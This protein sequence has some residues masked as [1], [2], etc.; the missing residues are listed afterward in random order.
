MKDARFGEPAGGQFRH[1]SPREAV[2]LASSPKRSPPEVGHVMS[3]RGERPSI[4][5]DCV[6]GEVAGYDLLQPGS[7]DG[8]RLMHSTPQLRLDVLQLR[9]LA[10]PPGLPLKLEVAS[11]GATADVGEAQERKGFRSAE[12]ALRAPVRR[13]ASELDQAGLFPMERQ[14][15]RVEPLTHRIEEATSVVLVLEADHEV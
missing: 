3:E 4:R 15:E 1:T 7:L 14:R 13:M 6:I 11:A 5:G 8:D 9:P 2:L 10:I 12:P